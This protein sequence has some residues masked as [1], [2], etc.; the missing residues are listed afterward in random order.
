MLASGILLTAAISHNAMVQ[1][2]S[3]PE[4]LQAIEHIGTLP[5]P[6]A[7]FKWAVNPDFTDEFEGDQLDAEKWYDKSPYWK[8]GRPPATFKAYNVSVENSCLRI[9]NSRLNPT[10]GNDGKPGTKYSYAGGAVASKSD[11]AWYGYYEVRMKASR[12]PMSSTF[13]LKNLAAGIIP[14]RETGIIEEILLHNRFINPQESYP[15]W[16][17]VLYDHVI[18]EPNIELMLNTHAVE[19]NMASSK[20]ISARCWQLRRMSK[21]DG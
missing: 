13:W 11:Q 3:K 15:V 12:T 19:A 14:E 7:G 6:P 17:H 16:D 18:R 21:K 5:E 10:E 9:K 4:Y 2:N 20:I 1:K 8:N